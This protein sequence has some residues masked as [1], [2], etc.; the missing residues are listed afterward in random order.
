M[1]YFIQG[2]DGQVY[3]PSELEDIN[4]WIVEGRVVPTTLLQPEDSQMRVAAAT[5]SG[6]VW[7]ENQSFQAYTPQVLSTAKYEFTGSWTCFGA[8]IALCCIPS[9]GAHISLGVGG[10]I[11][12]IMA[13]RKGR[14]WAIA[15]LL[16]NLSLVVF[17]IWVRRTTGNSM[18]LHE[19][20]NRMKDVMPR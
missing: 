7:G 14:I 15:P 4:K 9:F 11:L 12:S 6:L 2:A 17:W 13:Y 18:Q 1:R 19:M 16:L 5:I 3:G 10:A 20:M 8:S